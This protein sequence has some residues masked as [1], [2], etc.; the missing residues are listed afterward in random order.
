MSGAVSAT[1]AAAPAAGRASTLAL[2]HADWRRMRGTWL[3]P[4]TV[5][6]P[7]G[8][9]LLGVVLFLLRGEYMVGSFISGEKTG[10]QVVIDQIDM[11]HVFAIA[12]GAALIAS[13]IVDVEHRSDT[14]KQMF[15]LPVSRA[16][17]YA[18]KFAWGAG[19]L[20]VSSALMAVGY[21]GIMVWQDLGPLP[22]GNLAR[23]AWMPWV[24]VLPLFA[25]QLL[26]SALMK[27]QALPLA[28]GI[29]APMFGMVMS[30]IPAWLPWR[31]VSEAMTVA[32]G[33]AGAVGPGETL[34]G[35]SPT[36]IA[37]AS[38]A[39]VLVFVTVGAVV[40]ARREIR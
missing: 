20:A 23:V 7:L 17:S 32:V 29:I 38:G 16:R 5:L 9:T 12:L 37:A 30:E 10:W 8:V 40:L 14:W 3:L 34:S 36:Q 24:A 2:V 4:L 21:A 31:L 15:G 33:G 18:V 13:M 35:L 19:L 27:N 28:V 1:R 39:W 11:V 22:W 26:L 25:L 6:G